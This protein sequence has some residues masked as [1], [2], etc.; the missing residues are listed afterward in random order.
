M[1]GKPVAEVTG[2]GTGV[3]D[4]GLAKKIVEG[5]VPP[6]LQGKRII[7]LDLGLLVAGAIYR[8]DFEKVFNIRKLKF[9][10]VFHPTDCRPVI[11]MIFVKK[12]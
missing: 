1:T 6:A 3:D 7:A 12:I 2:R 11:R 10:Y 8:G 5:T 4:Q 9:L